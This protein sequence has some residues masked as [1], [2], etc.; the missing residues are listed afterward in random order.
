MILK[1][2]F[3]YLNL[4][5]EPKWGRESNNAAVEILRGKNVL[6]LDDLS[7]A[8]HIEGDFSLL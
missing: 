6:I 2:F 5:V 3:H 4:H 1:I 7:A 8:S